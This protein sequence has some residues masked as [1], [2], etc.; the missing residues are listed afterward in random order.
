[1]L[2]S[3]GPR[4]FLENPRVL[5]AKQSSGSKNPGREESPRGFASYATHNMESKAL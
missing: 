3:R 1:M 5:R 2:L 4:D